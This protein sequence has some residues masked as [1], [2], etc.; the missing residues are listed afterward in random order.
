VGLF[1]H[2]KSI[3]MHK[4]YPE[5]YFG[6]IYF[7]KKMIEGIEWLAKANG[8]TK[9]EFANYIMERGLS[10]FCGEQIELYNRATIAN[11]QASLPIKTKR[12]I[13]VIRRMAKEQGYH[14]DQLIPPRAKR[15]TGET[16][17]K[18]SG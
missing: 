10:S 7:N 6:H 17:G 12:T 3:N 1:A 5:E 8:A 18:N 14:V 11:R 13:A 16:N 9:K 2:K 4:L 15:S